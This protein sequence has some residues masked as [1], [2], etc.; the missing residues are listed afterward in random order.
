MEKITIENFAMQHVDDVML[1]ADLA[2][3]D[4]MI[5][6]SEDI[7]Q[8]L[9]EL[10]FPFRVGEVISYAAY[11]GNMVARS[12]NIHSFVFVEI[13]EFNPF[14]FH[15]PGLTIGPI[16]YNSMGE[17]LKLRDEYNRRLRSV[18]VYNVVLAKEG[19]TLQ[20]VTLDNNEAIVFK[21]LLATDLK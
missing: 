16:D 17:I 15:V 13:C 12:I 14:T 19:S 21:R 9:I 6:V 5:F 18:S 2:N 10:T 11:K 3:G 8:K 4:R 7:F 1:F 20:I